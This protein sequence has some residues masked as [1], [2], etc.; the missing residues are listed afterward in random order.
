MIYFMIIAGTFLAGIGINAVLTGCMRNLIRETEDM[1]G[2]DNGFLKQMKL[3]YKNCMRIGREIHNTEAFAGKYMDRYTSYGLSI[4][5]YE[6]I[7]SVCSGICV[8][9][10]VAGAFMYE[11]NAMYF[12]LMGFLAMYVISGLKR[13]T[14]VPAKR[15]KILRNIVDYFE[16][17]FAAATD[18]TEQENHTHGEEQSVKKGFTEEEKRIIDDILREYLG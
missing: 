18:E 13:M 4:S 3:R 10:A 14:D 15:K 9:T 5:V 2:T 1:E 6:K 17:R 11:D 8:I 7:I 16:N 12:L